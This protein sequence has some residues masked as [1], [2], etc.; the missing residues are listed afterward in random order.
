MLG[1]C[2]VFFLH[3][4]KILA[5]DYCLEFLNLISTAEPRVSKQDV[6]KEEKMAGSAHPTFFARSSNLEGA[7]NYGNHGREITSAAEAVGIY[8]G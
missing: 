4:S 8:V 3:Y 6:A 7:M 1:N 5:I 2:Q